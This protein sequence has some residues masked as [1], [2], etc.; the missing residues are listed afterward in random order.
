MSLDPKRTIRELKELRDLTAR[1]RIALGDHG[2]GRIGF[3][4]K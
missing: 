3:R 4:G 2:G 1:G